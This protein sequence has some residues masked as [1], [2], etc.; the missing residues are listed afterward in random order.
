[1]AKDKKINK[2]QELTYELKVKD[3]MIKEVVTV[4]PKIAI[5]ELR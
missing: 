2:I 4:S 3:V 5:F 1:M